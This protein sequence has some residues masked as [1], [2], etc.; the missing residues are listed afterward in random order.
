MEDSN[1]NSCHL[2]LLPS[3]LEEGAADEK[4]NVHG[5]GLLE[6]AREVQEKGALHLQECIQIYKAAAGCREGCQEI[7]CRIVML[8]SISCF[9]SMASLPKVIFR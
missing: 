4:D 7:D 2:D 3:P 5:R 1:I 9:P 8:C 6:V